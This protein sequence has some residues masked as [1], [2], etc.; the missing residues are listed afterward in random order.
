MIVGIGTQRFSLSHQDCGLL[1]QFGCSHR[2]STP[3]NLTIGTYFWLE[4][5]QKQTFFMNYIILSYYY[6]II[7][8]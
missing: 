2:H 1:T 8:L 5:K 4:T 7:V 3:S 6:Y